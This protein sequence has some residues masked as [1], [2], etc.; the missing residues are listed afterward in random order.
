M[1][2]KVMGIMSVAPIVLLLFTGVLFGI[3]F[4]IAAD[5][6]EAGVP[7][8]ITALIVELAAVA[9][10]WINIIWFIILACKK[11]T[12]TTGKKHYGVY[13]FIALMFLYFLY[14]GGSIP[15]VNSANR[16]IGLTGSYGR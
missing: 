11:Q 10:V 7:L 14:F 1:K 5:T 9:I 6:P 2:N 4:C 16:I 13:W 15:K 8:Y 3:G 12:W